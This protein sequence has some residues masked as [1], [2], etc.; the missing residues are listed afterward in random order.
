MNMNA[1]KKRTHAHA[2]GT[3][4]G[5]VAGAVAGG[6]GLSS[7]STGGSNGRM[8]AGKPI[9]R[10]VP[11]PPSH[12]PAFRY[13]NTRGSATTGMSNG[14]AGGGGDDEYNEHD[15]EVA[16][17]DMHSSLIRTEFQ[18]GVSFSIQHHYANGKKKTVGAKQ[19]RE[20]P[21]YGEQ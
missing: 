11:P 10:V 12:P 6:A 4:V 3:G 2:H 19:F 9:E 15:H 7:R 14:R 18:N 5:A 21:K 1:H 13:P 16:D 20:L 17:D 8:R